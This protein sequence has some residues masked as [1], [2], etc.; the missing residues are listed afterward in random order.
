MDYLRW[1]VG[2]AYMQGI[3][4]FVSSFDMEQSFDKL[5]I[6]TATQ[7]YHT[8]TGSLS[9]PS[10]G[11]KDVVLPW[12]L[13]ITPVGLRVTTDHSVTRRGFEILGAR[14]CCASTPIVGAPYLQRL[15][16]Y[17]ALLTST[18]D[19][20]YFST[21]FVAGA[22]LNIAVWG[23]VGDVDVRVRCGAYPTESQYDF[24]ATS[25]DSNEFLHITA[26]WLAEQC[27]GQSLYVAVS[28]FSIPI[29]APAHIMVS[30]IY[31]E[32]VLTLTAG[33][34]H[35]ATTQQLDK[36]KV[37]LEEAIRRSYGQTEGQVFIKQIDLWNSQGPG[38]ECQCNGVQ[39][40]ICFVLNGYPAPPA[41]CRYDDNNNI[42]TL[43]ATAGAPAPDAC[44]YTG[45]TIAHEFG[46]AYMSGDA[47]N[48]Q[49]HDE[50][51][52]FQGNIY[53]QCGHSNMADPWA[54]EQHNF[55][56][57][58]DHKKD[59]TPGAPTT[60]LVSVFRNATFAGVVPEAPSGTPDNYSFVGFDFNNL[61]AVY[62]HP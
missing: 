27:T 12:R 14:Y 9:G 16:R 23:G 48:E 39:C 46:H 54:I 44:W 22:G 57:D 25:S 41:Q 51:Y 31:P 62:V 30:A 49:I 11:Y 24:A 42:V 26:D 20:V 55:C 4:F 6:G 45:R 61:G 36:W 1:V 10:L 19:V 33:T 50:Y 52:N 38:Y 13:Q 53:W 43:S 28:A 35:T 15:R 47:I 17:T 29:P 37:A 60:T 21:D 56:S 3:S 59:P 18:N 7:N 40:D 2:N 34:D 58:F 8:L 5:A 32:K